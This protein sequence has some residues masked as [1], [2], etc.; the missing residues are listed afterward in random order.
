[1][2]K[3]TD[4]LIVGGGVGGSMAAIAAARKGCSVMLI[5]RG[6]CLGGMWTAG[7]VGFTLDSSN[8]DGL[9]KEFLTGVNQEQEKNAATIFEIQK[10][11]LEKMCREAGVQICYHSQV[12]TVRVCGRNIQSVRVITKSGISEIE[13]VV[14][15]D[16]TGDGDVASMAG[17]GF[18]YGRISDR[19]AQPMSMIALISG[20]DQRALPYIS[21]P[22]K[23]FWNARLRLKAILDRVGAAYSI[24][25]PSI[26][27]LCDGLY[28]LSANQEYGKNG[29]NVDELTEATIQARAEIYHMVQALKSGA[30]EV[31]N[32]LA[33]AATPECIGVREG[34]RIH[35]RYTITV[36][37][38]IAGKRHEDAVC[39]VRDWVDIHSLEE[40]D[41]SGFTDDGIKAQPF[42][43]P[44]RSLLAADIDNLILAGR[45]ISGDFYAHACYR[46]AGDMAPVGEAAGRMA[47]RAVKEGVQPWELKYDSHRY[48]E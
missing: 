44:F 46:V 41:G 40:N 29:C 22:D 20:L 32:N 21:Y 38:I 14:V 9:L 42:D 7:F 8:K 4:I 24:N 31:F 6:G 36:D 25:C 43:I 18:E 48:D 39:L 13:S 2:K 1:M 47:A 19:K 33:L 10:Y 17:C 15:I 5:E 26:Q 28:I 30:P 45:C 23:P 27:P 16:A 11:L 3:T 12:C 34:R 35:G 37:D